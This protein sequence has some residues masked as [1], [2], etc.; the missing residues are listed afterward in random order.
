[1]LPYVYVFYTVCARLCICSKNANV[2][3]SAKFGKL[4]GSCLFENAAVEMPMSTSN[5][6]DKHAEII[7]R[8]IF[9]LY[10]ITHF[11]TISISRILHFIRTVESGDETTRYTNNTDCVMM[12]TTSDTSS[13]SYIHTRIYSYST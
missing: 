1:M 2:Q 11:Y 5:L 13:S 4:F 9:Y 6:C 3:E 12:V 8:N 10:H 7:Q